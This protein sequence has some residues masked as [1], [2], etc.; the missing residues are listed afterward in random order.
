MI[1]NKFFLKLVGLI[2][3]LLI[4]GCAA[5]YKL[6][7]IY[8]QQESQLE[9]IALYPL[10]YSQDGKEQRLFGLTFSQVFFNEVNTMSYKRPI[11]FILPDSTV[12]IFEE[13]G[14]SVKNTVRGI[15]DKS[16]VSTE[17]PVYKTVSF[18]ELESISD[19]VDGFIFCDLLSY[20]EVGAGEELGQA[21]L[22]ACLTLGMV[23]YSE[24]NV[25]KMRISLLSTK[26]D[27]VLW[28]YT[29]H[30][31]KSLSGR[32]NTRSG[33]TTDIVEGFRKYFPLSKE[34]QSK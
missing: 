7:P 31:T 16:D 10:H 17:Y 30:F 21:L 4:L 28:E 1:K 6:M 23:S 22:T 12:S 14:V 18:S 24:N 3:L 19:K 11:Q 25:V 29:P 8:D 15:V 5:P 27:S 13:A 26:V 33:F 2:I 34:F 32:E 20:N 9:T